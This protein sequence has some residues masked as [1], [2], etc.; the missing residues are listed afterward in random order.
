MVQNATDVFTGLGAPSG[1][2]VT[3]DSNDGWYIAD[4]QMSGACVEGVQTQL[5]YDVAKA[6]ARLIAAAPCLLAACRR[7][8]LALAFAAETAPAMWD[9]YK[10]VSDAIAK[11][12]QP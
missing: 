10:A 8:V 2:G 11:A 4:V 6:N 1:D 3:A 5:C 12:T 7:A 9:D